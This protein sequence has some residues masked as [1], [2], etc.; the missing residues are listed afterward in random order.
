M[1]QKSSL[2]ESRTHINIS[3]LKVK[4]YVLK[5][6][7]GLVFDQAPLVSQSASFCKHNHQLS[8]RPWIPTYCLSM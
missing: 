3:E 7:I 1:I 8:F 4:C 2:S 6:K 5:N